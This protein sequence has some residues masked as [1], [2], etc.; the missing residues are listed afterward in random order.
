[1][2]CGTGLH[3]GPLGCGVEGGAAVIHTHR[4]MG[5]S[6]WAQVCMKGGSEPCRY[7]TGGPSN[8]ANK[9]K[10]P[11]ASVS[12]AAVSESRTGRERGCPG[13]KSFVGHWK[14]LDLILRIR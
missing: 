4:A 8:G 7:L 11:E 3:N 6:Q 5:E 1:M 9:C 2:P 12:R 14:A 10:G 13:Q